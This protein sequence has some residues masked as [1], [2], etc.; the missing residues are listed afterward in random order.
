[1]PLSLLEAIRNLD[2]PLEDGLHDMAPEQDPRRLGLSATV[3]AQIRRYAEQVERDE[4][5]PRDEAV[6]VFRLV[7]RRHPHKFTML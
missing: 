2:T 4:S 3:A 1:M 6:S 5:V 7:G